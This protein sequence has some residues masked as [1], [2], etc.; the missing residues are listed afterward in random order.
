MASPT[1]GGKKRVTR[2]FNRVQLSEEQKQEIKEAFDLFD[3]DGSGS[4]DAKELK[5]VFD[6]SKKPNN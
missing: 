3:T 1:R 5:E 2:D 6:F 4:I